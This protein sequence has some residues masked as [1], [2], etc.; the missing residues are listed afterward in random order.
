MSE[1]RRDPGGHADLIESARA[2][3]AASAATAQHDPDAVTQSACNRQAI[4]DPG[5]GVDV[6]AHDCRSFMIVDQGTRLTGRVDGLEQQ[7]TRQ[8]GAFSMLSASPL[9]ALAGLLP[10]RIDHPSFPV[11]PTPV[12][13]RGQTLA[14]DPRPCQTD[15]TAAAADPPPV[16]A[17]REH[18]ASVGCHARPLP[19]VAAQSAQHLPR[20]RPPRPRLVGRCQHPNRIWDRGGERFSRP[21]P[22]SCGK[23]PDT[24]RNRPAADGG[25]DQLPD[26]AYRLPDSHLGTLPRCRSPADRRG[27]ARSSLPVARS[28]VAMK[29]RPSP[30][31]KTVA[32]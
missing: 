1:V 5:K 28:S 22:L 19:R 26:D 18:I 21:T 27:R 11:T 23:A 31:S 17:A 16:P 20:R 29:R 25:N 24:P 15:A 4:G 6:P 3:A 9:P 8:R 32:G 10:S 14:S 7:S 12:G 13:L 30:I 2:Q